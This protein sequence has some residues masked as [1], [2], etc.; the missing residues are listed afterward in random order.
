MTRSLRPAKA[1]LAIISI[2]AL[3]ALLL[4]ACSGPSF[5]LSVTLAGDGSGSVQANFFSADTDRDFTF[6]SGTVV[7][8]VAE[9]DTG[10]VFT[11][12]S[13][14]CDGTGRFCEVTMDGDKSA[15][16]TFAPAPAA[17]SP[18]D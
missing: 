7:D 17:A 16:A 18:T 15:T 8:L 14:A 4:A 10:S 1:K 6:E 13:G 11:G 5:T 12:W 2:A 3:A 9:P